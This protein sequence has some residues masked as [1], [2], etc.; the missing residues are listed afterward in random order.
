MRPAGRYINMINP[1]WISLNYEN[2]SGDIFLD[3]K[4]IGDFLVKELDAVYLDTIKTSI[5]TYYKYS[6]NDLAKAYHSIS[7]TYRYCL[8]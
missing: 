4:K 2:K 3:N 7:I 8:W 1:N 5:G 6:V